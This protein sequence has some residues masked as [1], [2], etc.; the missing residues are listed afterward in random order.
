MTPDLH[1]VPRAPGL[2]RA[3]SVLLRVLTVVGLRVTFVPASGL[4]AAGSRAT[5]AV[6]AEALAVAGLRRPTMV[7]DR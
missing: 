2:R 3:T 4:R 1:N 6:P 5:T 7:A